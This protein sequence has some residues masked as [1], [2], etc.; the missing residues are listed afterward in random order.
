MM[1]IGVDLIDAARLSRVLRKVPSLTG[2]CYSSRELSCA[3]LLPA[4]RRRD[5]LAGRFAAKE[6]VLKALRLE[7][8]NGEILRQI[9][10]LKRDDGSPHLV[11]GGTAAEAAQQLEIEGQVSISH[12]GS[13]AYAVAMFSPR[14]GW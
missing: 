7:L 5:F 6:A 4:A 1:R 14:T 12:D 2:R 3:T 11:L 10:V 13:L 9:E 8:G